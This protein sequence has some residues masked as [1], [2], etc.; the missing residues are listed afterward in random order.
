MSRFL[1]LLAIAAAALAP[2]AAAPAAAQDAPHQR[3]ARAVLERLVTFR[4]AAGHA[5][6]PAMADYIVE[7]L[8]AGGFPAED[9]VRLPHDD[10]VG[11]L[12][13]VP[14]RDPS[15]RP[16][17]FSGH[18]D[19]V[20][21]RPED[22]ERDPFRLIEENGYLFGRGVED[23]KTGI[24]S[25]VSALLRMRADGFRPRRTL[26]FAFVG[27]E[28]TTF[29]TTRLIAAHP[30]VRSAE[31]AINTDA[32]G[33]GL[34]PDGRALVYL[35]QGAEKTYA[36]FRLTATNPGGHSSRPRRDNAIYDLSRALLRVEQYRFPAMA[37]A[38]TRAY[39]GT[40]AG[41]VTGEAG[42]ALRA[43]ADDPSDATAEALYDSAEYVGA[44]RTTCVATMAEAGH[45]ENALPQRASAMVNCRIFP[46]VE[47]EAVRTALAEA[48]ANPAIAVETTG[49]PETGPVSE[50]REDVMAAIARS[51][52][53]RHPDIPISP[54]LEAGATD[55]V[56]YRTAGI[57]TFGTSGIFV[58]P[59]EI[60]AHGLN[61]RIPVA[62]FYEAIDHVHDLAVDLGGDGR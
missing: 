3:Q 5:Q 39:L 50:M 43:F 10:T 8:R 49:D 28:E 18:M 27:D 60:F 45:A 38:L 22:W 19:V 44:T 55:G 57:P 40:L 26:V 12:V 1:T 17:L 14:G 56:V 51:V 21:A 29:G 46:G 62:S 59:D 61:E 25:M 52:H 16:L 6:V 15:A 24:A 36:T 54:Y 58:K 33:G 34:A 4:S 41:L 20:D 35:V 37:N 30:W 7:T 48:V 13:R 31:Y 32:G 23:N 9:I 53:R 2:L 42:A 11:L 47:V